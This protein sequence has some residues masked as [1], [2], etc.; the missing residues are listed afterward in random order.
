MTLGGPQVRSPQQR[1]T[2]P[3]SPQSGRRSRREPGDKGD[4]HYDGN[5]NT[6]DQGWFSYIGIIFAAQKGIDHKNIV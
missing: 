4:D 6:D 5:D 3:G 2:W 1:A